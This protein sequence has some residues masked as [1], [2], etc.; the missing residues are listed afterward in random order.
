MRHRLIS[1]SLIGCLAGCVDPVAPT[2]NT[3][4]DVIV[5]DG[6]VTDLAEP[7]VIWFTRS[8]AD[9]FT[10][11]FGETPLTG[12]QAS[13]LV[14]GTESIP[15]REIRPGAY[16]LPEGFRGRVGSRYQLQ[17]R[18]SNG[19][20]Y[21]STAE[22]LPAV[23]PIDT[24]TNQ[25][26]P[27][28][29]P[30]D[31][32]LGL[33]A[34][35]DLH[36]STKDPAGTPNYYRWDWVLWERQDFCHTCPQ[37][38]VYVERDANNQLI[39][40]CVLNNIVPLPFPRPQFVDYECRTQCWEILFSAQLNQFA[41]TY[42]DGQ[43]IANRRVAQI[44]FYPYYP[45]LVEVRQSALTP[46]AHAYFRRLDEQSQRTGGLTDTPPAAPVGNIRNLTDERENVVGYFTASGVSAV[47]YWLDRKNVT[48]EVPF[49]T[50]AEFATVF[51]TVLNQRRPFKEPISGIRGRPPLAVC[52]PSDSR[53]PVKPAGWRE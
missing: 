7:Q 46:E 53:T 21:E 32:T 1:L 28:S 48:N 20:R 40:G 3:L 31:R 47:R 15:A 27:R 49:P 39:E 33:T 37:N 34:A 19:T 35:H 11:R 50:S 10:G 22:T 14:N 43:V 30:P 6:T 13:V 41:D 5:V 44:P 38:F 25:Y 16:Q 29:L 9:R 4:V 26:N 45:A 2:F 51:F 42:S 23:P 17:F 18:L 24:V 8:T 12:V 52:V 36:V